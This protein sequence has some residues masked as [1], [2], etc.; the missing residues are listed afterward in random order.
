MALKYCNWQRETA[1]LHQHH[2]LHHHTPR[3]PAPPVDLAV[4]P[5]GSPLN[6]T[7][8]ATMI[9]VEHGTPSRVRAPCSPTQT[10]LPAPAVASSPFIRKSARAAF[11]SIAEEAASPGSMGT[12]R[13]SNGCLIFQV[14]SGSDSVGGFSCISATYIF[15]S[16]YSIYQMAV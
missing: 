4:D 8:A 2:R 14:R 6:P 5:A 1:L 3:Q 16:I 10:P 12:V 15:L 11:D 9:K 7:I 13:I